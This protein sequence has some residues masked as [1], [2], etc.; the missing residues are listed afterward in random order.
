MF[1]T[2]PRYKIESFTSLRSCQDKL[3]STPST[4]IPPATYR[5]INGTRRGLLA[6]IECTKRTRGVRVLEISPFAWK[7]NKETKPKKKKQQQ[8]KNLCP[9][10]TFDLIVHSTIIHRWRSWH[11]YNTMKPHL[12]N[13]LKGLKASQIRKW[14]SVIAYDPNWGRSNMEW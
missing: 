7:T 12:L 6:F 1:G 13:W 3:A 2:L 14:L 9:L 5:L 11:M 8:Q 4:S 10:S